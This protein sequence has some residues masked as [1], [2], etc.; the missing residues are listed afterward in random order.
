MK[1]NMGKLLHFRIALGEI[2]GIMESNKNE[3]VFGGGRLL[4]TEHV[5]FFFIL[6]DNYSEDTSM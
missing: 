5:T 4:A 1:F 3:L 2:P 6:V